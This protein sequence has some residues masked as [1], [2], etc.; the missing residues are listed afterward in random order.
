MV[1]GVRDALLE[2]EEL[3]GD[4]IEAL[5][6]DLGEREPIEVPVTG[7]G[8]GPRGSRPGA[9]GSGRRQRPPVAAAAPDYPPSGVA[10]AGVASGSTVSR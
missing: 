3:I 9:T 5:M 2:R 10:P 4:E 6:A 1:E 8:A 7:D